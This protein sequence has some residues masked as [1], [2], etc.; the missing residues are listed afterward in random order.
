MP[1]EDVYLVPVRREVARYE[2]GSLIGSVV[3]RRDVVRGV[4]GG[5]LAAD[6]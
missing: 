3:P 5:W 6:H 4:G 2:L 1:G